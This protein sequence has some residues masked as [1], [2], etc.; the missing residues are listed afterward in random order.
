MLTSFKLLLATCFVV[1]FVVW[2]TH[3]ELT[4]SLTVTKDTTDAAT[5]LKRFYSNDNTDFRR[6]NQKESM[7]NENKS[8]FVYF[9]CQAA[10]SVS[11][12]LIKCL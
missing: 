12:N 7:E 8:K 11:I 4:S 9:F 2:F 3:Y 10:L 6:K 1:L 5:I